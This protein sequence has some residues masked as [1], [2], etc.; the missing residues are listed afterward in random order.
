MCCAF[1][2]SSKILSTSL[3]S[4]IKL[5]WLFC[6]KLAYVYYLKITHEKLF[7]FCFCVK[8]GRYVFKFFVMTELLISLENIR[9][10]QIYIM[11]NNMQNMT[12]LYQCRMYMYVRISTS[13]VQ[14]QVIINSFTCTSRI[15]QARHVYYNSEI[16]SSEAANLI[17]KY[18]SL[19]ARVSVSTYI[20]Q[21]KHCK[22]VSQVFNP[23]GI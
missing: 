7:I 1:M 19:K 20:S 3:S 12:I 21:G 6:R 5:F 9:T 2:F 23:K 15:R 11:Q 17:A 10:E 8:S 13:I 16:A 14:V 22:Q 4:I 18:F